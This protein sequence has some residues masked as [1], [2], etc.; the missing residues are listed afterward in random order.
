MHPLHYVY[1]RVVNHCIM[2][3]SSRF[4]GKR[5]NSGSPSSS[6]GSSSYLFRGSPPPPFPDYPRFNLHVADIQSKA[7]D[8]PE[9]SI[10]RYLPSLALRKFCKT[11]T[12]NL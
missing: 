5:E 10:D 12:F 8:F 9:D 3:S 7:V 11:K 1:D 4:S 6:N 2:K